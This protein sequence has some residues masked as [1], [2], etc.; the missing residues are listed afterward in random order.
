MRAARATR[1]P[2]AEAT[3]FEDDE[4]ILGNLIDTVRELVGVPAVLCIPAVGVYR[5][6]DTGISSNLQIVLEG[7]ARKCGVVYFQ[8]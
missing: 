2:A 8:V 6:E 3:C 1:A 7:V 5:S 4:H